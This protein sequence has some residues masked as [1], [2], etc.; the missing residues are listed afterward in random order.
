ME[1]QRY[2]KNP[3]KNCDIPD[4]FKEH[5]TLDRLHNALEDLKREIKMLHPFVEG[6][7]CTINEREQRG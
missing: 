3:C 1:S 6:Y 7:R 5:C 2:K 4:F